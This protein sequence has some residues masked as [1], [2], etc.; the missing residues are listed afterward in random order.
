MS[1]CGE[2]SKLVIDRKVLQ[3][4]CFTLGLNCND[5]CKEIKKKKKEYVIST[6][7]AKVSSDLGATMEDAFG[8]IKR[9]DFYKHLAKGFKELRKTHY[10]LRI[11][12]Q[13]ELIKLDDFERVM[14][15]CDDLIAIMADMQKPKVIE[16]N[17]AYFGRLYVGKN[18]YVPGSS[19]YLDNP[20]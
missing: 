11:L 14:D 7:L 13:C 5:L 2:E 4:K 17:E 12:E 3:G 18:K 8:S 19:S 10:L 15:D 6:Q 20:Y 1:R 9:K 16:L